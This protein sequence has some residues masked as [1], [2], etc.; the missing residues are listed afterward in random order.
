MDDLKTNI[1]LARIS[2]GMSQADLAYK[3]GVSKQS[4]CNYEAGIRTPAL[5]TLKA[6]AAALGLSVDQ[7]TGDELQAED[8][9][10]MAQNAV[11]RTTPADAPVRPFERAGGIYTSLPAI[12]V[13]GNLQANDDGSICLGDY[14]GWATADVNDPTK[15]F[16]WQCTKDAMEPNVQPGDLL[17]V[18][19]QDDVDDGDMAIVIRPEIGGRLCRVRKK[20]DGIVMTFDKPGEEDVVLRT[21][22]A[23][24]AGKVKRLVRAYE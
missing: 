4:V 1:K 18:H 8:A 16:Y 23:T 19:I 12:R 14:R 17:L 21:G 3:I 9:I 5:S 11:P 6:M 22:E 20:E 2:R 24:I 15:Y 7:L 13:V 10:R